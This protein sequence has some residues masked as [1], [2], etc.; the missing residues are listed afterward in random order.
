MLGRHKARPFYDTK[1]MQQNWNTVI[2]MDINI[3]VVLPLHHYF[4]QSQ[5]HPPTSP[6]H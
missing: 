2:A 1:Y 5:T 4:D 6:H 3:L